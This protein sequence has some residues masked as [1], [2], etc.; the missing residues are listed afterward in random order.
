V[1]RKGSKSCPASGTRRVILFTNTVISHEGGKD[2][3]VIGTIG[4]Y[5]WSFVI[6]IF[7]NVLFVMNAA[8][9]NISVKCCGVNCRCLRETGVF[10]ENH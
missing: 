3:F 10:G 4:T 6:Q 2:S 8:F 1:F 5:P 7:R 9:E